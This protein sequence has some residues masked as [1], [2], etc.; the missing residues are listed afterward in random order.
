MTEHA[1]RDAPTSGPGGPTDEGGA[2]RRRGSLA[3]L[4]VGL[5]ALVVSL[6]QTVLI[7][8]LAGLPEELNTSADN[9]SWLLTS[10]LLVGAITVPIFGR[11]ADMFGKRLLLLVAIA[12]LAV[13]SFLTAVTDSVPLLILGRSIQGASVAAVP[14]GISLLASILPRERAGSAIALVSAMLGIGGALGL[15]LSGLIAQSFDFHALFWMTGVA[16]A[17][18]FVGILFVVPESPERSGGRVDFI[19]AT[20]LGIGLLCLMLPLSKG[21]SWG[22]DSASVWALL[23]IS[24]VVLAIFTW[25]QVK[26]R[27]PLVDMKALRSRPI[28]LTNVAS[29]LFGFALFASMIGTA[30]FIQAPA[31]AGYGFGSS[32]LVGGLAMLPSGIAMLLFSPLAAKLIDRRGA[33]QTL[34]LGATI[35]GLGWLARMVFTSSLTEVIIG[36]TIVGIGTGIGYASIPTLINLHSPHAEIAAA[37]GLNTLFR[38]FGSSLASTIGASILAGSTVALGAAVLPSLDAYRELF[39]VCALASVLAAVVAI[40]VPRYAAQK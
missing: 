4:F 8:V 5:G 38:T 21:S 3:I 35:V 30:G 13:G 31:E 19:G 32:V 10:T 27:E 40:F 28:V 11:L 20:L 26:I 1:V 23:A 15:P 14:L 6:S 16:G 7:P 34:A 25:S 33:P 18:A 24:V 22:W 37:N 12:A 39:A 2:A 9:V 17:L 29:I 36:A